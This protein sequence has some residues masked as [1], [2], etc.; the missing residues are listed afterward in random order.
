MAA[1]DIRIGSGAGYQG[2][3][4][5]PALELVCEV[6]LDFLFLECLVRAGVSSTE[7]TDAPRS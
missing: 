2:D 3:R 1:R 4:V 5:L 7:E 6:Q